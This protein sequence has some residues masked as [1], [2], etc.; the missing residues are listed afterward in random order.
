MA[1]PREKAHLQA[2]LA[3]T[4][5]LTK[6]KKDNPWLYQ[7][8]SIILRS[9]C[10]RLAAAFAG[11]F[12]RGYG[13]PEPKGRYKSTPGFD[14]A[15]KPKI[16]K[17][18]IY[19]GKSIGWVRIQ[20][21]LTDPYKGSAKR[22]KVTFTYDKS[23]DEWEVCVVYEAKI[24]ETENNGLAI[25]V[26][27]NVEQCADSTGAIFHLN[28]L[29]QIKRYIRKRK[30]HQKIAARRVGAK[31]GEKSSNRRKKSLNRAAKYYRKEKNCRLNMFHHYANYLVSQCSNIVLEDL[32]IKGM[33][34]KGKGKKGLNRSILGS[35]WGILERIL[36]Y[37]AHV[38]LK[39]PP[40]YTSQTC[41]KCGH[42]HKDNR[43]GRQFKCLSCGHDRPCRH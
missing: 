10:K 26:D 9:A 39:V 33:T 29:N 7:Y 14:W 3:F 16:K 19:L 2:I 22:V 20:R 27:R 42:I 25:S 17:G 32:N 40:Q 41:S 24:A 5:E 6:I 30:K 4:L 15:D 12:E 18:R 38:L 13:F 43:K 8:H 36:G 11:F 31:K 28:L 1:N 23:R 35:G 21:R 37:K 34:K